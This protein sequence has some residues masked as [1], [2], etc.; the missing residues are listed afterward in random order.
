MKV[1]KVYI[2]IVL[3]SL[4]IVTIACKRE[5]FKPNFEHAAGYVIKKETC[6]TNTDEDYWLV[7]LSHPLN[8]ITNY[9]DTITID[10]RFYTNMIK[11]T[12]LPASFKEIGMHV[13][14]DFYISDTNIETS[15]CTVANP[16]TYNLKE[17]NIIAFGIW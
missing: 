13:S 6:K 11:T 3:C 16:I 9:G 10:G 1:I 8:T 7:D 5:P 15:E 2:A 4:L 17:I 12:K 14:F